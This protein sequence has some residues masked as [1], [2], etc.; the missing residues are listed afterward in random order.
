MVRNVCS[1]KDYPKAQGAVSVEFALPCQ[2]SHH[3][4]YIM[5]FLGIG[6]VDCGG[7]DKVVTTKQALVS[8][9]C[10]SWLGWDCVQDPELAVL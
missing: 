4:F 9:K 2:R 3:G 8:A 1:L 6:A 5:N 7:E 10:G